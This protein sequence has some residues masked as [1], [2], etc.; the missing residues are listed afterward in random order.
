MT[1]ERQTHRLPSWWP[2]AGLGLLL[3][4]SV[5]TLMY[6]GRGGSFYY[7]DWNFVLERHDWNTGALLRA[8][9]EHLSVVP[10]LAYKLLFETVGLDD[11]APYR[12]L[13]AFTHAG[14]LAAIFLY[15]RPRVGRCSRCS[16]P[17]RIAIFGAAYIDLL[18]AFQLG[19][20]AS[21]LTGVLAFVALDRGTRRGDIA[22]CVLV[23]VSIAASSVGLC[24]LAGI[25]VDV[26]AAPTGASAGGSWR[27]R[28]CCTWPGG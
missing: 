14:T 16:S 24:V 12:L 11:Y 10:V 13:L 18:W 26:L 19:Y 20:S 6:Q 17:P 9:N 4:W 28:P 5:A 22:A 1:T 25:V 8:H 2:W 21:L 3:V 23:C 7:D 27:C 15:A